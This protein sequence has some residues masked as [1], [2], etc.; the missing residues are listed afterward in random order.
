MCPTFKSSFPLLALQSPLVLPKTAGQGTP[1]KGSQKGSCQHCQ[2][3]SARKL[4]SLLGFG[5]G[6][7]LCQTLSYD[8]SKW[9]MTCRADEFCVWSL[10]WF[11]LITVLLSVPP[12]I[13]YSQGDICPQPPFLPPHRC[14]PSLIFCVV[15]KKTFVI[16]NLTQW[17]STSLTKPS[18]NV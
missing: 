6:K 3:S 12:F 4:L 2:S 8:I 15:W 7:L 13:Q 17:T 16:L 14:V 9:M 11:A 18:A 1:G 10:T 5:A